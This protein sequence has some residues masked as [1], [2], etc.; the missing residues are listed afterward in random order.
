MNDPRTCNHERFRS[1][2]QVIHTTERGPSRRWR[3]DVRVICEECGTEM[4]FVGL[5]EGENAELLGCWVAEQG[6]EARLAI[7]PSIVSHPVQPAP[8]ARGTGGQAITT[9]T[10]PPTVRRT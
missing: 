1:H 8:A 7:G 5:P 9:T 6:R 3:V 2:T 4:K 10:P